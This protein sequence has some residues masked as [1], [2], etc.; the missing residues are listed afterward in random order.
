MKVSEIIE[1]S[2]IKQSNQIDHADAPE[3]SAD[4]ARRIANRAKDKAKQANPGDSDTV[5]GWRSDP[6]QGGHASSSLYR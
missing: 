4:K 3:S 2:L 5:T 1:G 6:H